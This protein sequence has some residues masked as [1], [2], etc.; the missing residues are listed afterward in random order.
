MKRLSLLIVVILALLVAACGGQ[1]AAP[2]AAPTA[3]AAVKAAAPTVAAAVQQAAPTVAAAVAPKATE[4]PKAAAP[5]AATE[6]PK[7]AAPAATLA[8]PTPLPTGVTKAVTVKPG[9]TKV[10]FWHAMGGALGEETQKLVDGFNASQDK[11]VVEA[12][13]QGNYDN[14]LAKLRAGLATK[15]VPTLMQVYDIGTRLMTDLDVVTPMQT[16][17]DAEKYDISD[18][19]PAVLNYYSVNGKLQSMPFNTSG[20]IL[21]Y[22]KDAFAKA[23]LDPEKPPRTWQEV[24]DAAKALKEKAGMEC[25]IAQIWY[26][27]FFE[28]WQA[29]GGNYYADNENGRAAPATKAAFNTQYSQDLLKWMKDMIDNGTACNAGRNAAGG[30][31]AAQTAFEQQKAGMFIESTAR[32]RRVVDNTEGKGLF[33]VGTGWMPRQKVEDYDK[34]GTIIGGASLW[35]LKDR[36]QEEQQGAWEFIKYVAA[37]PQQAQWHVGT[38]YYPIRKSGYNDPKAVEWR[39]KYPQFNTAREQL[40][41]SPINNYTA[42]ALLGVFPSA[43]QTIE[44]GME[45]IMLGKVQIPAMLDASQQAITKEIETYN[46]TVR[47]R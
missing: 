11:Y 29:T 30:S 21:Y 10:T 3:A 7:A 14:S 18:L 2:S 4:A 27:W 12:T 24:A 43:R 25:G 46:R 44:K 6:A 42:G 41:K 31:D 23:G 36:P 5:A 38:G 28:Q 40:Q 13:F 9:Q 32:L 8:A 39:T 1:A 47:P 16:F 26:G 22:N 15:D 34:S 35:A 33:K 17:I 20:P 37:A 45:D 19:E